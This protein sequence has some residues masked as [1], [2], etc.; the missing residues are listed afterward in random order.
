METGVGVGAGVGVAAGL[1]LAAGLEDGWALAEAAGLSVTAELEDGVSE[2]AG[3]GV[4]V[5]WVLGLLV[6]VEPPE[7]LEE[8]YLSTRSRSFRVI[9]SS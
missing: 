4:A 1:L 2:V 9:F 3:V 6:L 5:G 8:P 7:E